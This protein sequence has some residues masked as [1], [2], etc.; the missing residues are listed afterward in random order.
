MAG[1]RSRC[2]TTTTP[3]IRRRRREREKKRERE[4]ERS[5]T[6]GDTGRGD[7]GDGDGESSWDVSGRSGDGGRLVPAESGGGFLG[8]KNAGFFK[9]FKDLF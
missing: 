2:S 1:T 5:M 9:S 6:R 4:G 7:G 3:G 8:E